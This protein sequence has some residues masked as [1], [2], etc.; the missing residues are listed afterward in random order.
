MSTMSHHHPHLNIGK[1]FGAVYIGCIVSTVL[2]GFTCNQTYVY[3]KNY[4]K[5]TW[6]TKALVGLRA[7]CDCC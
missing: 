4:K 6:K 7:A 2:Y 3:F 5:D 1:T